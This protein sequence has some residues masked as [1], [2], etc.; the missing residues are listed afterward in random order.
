[1][2]V[3]EEGLEMARVA[4]AFP[5]KVWIRLW[6]LRCF[7]KSSLLNPI[8]LDGGKLLFAPPMLC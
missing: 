7:W 8:L 4:P 5:G 1:M 6:N 2:P 3:G